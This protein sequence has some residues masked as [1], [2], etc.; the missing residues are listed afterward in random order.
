MMHQIRKMVGLILAISR[1]HVK[2]DILNKAFTLGKVNIPR[3][4]GLGLML[5]FVHYDRYNN[6][7][8]SDGVHDKLLWEEEKEKVD[9]FA[10]KYIFPTIIDTEINEKA[11]LTWLETKLSKHTFDG[12]QEEDANEEE[13]EDEGEEPSANECKEEGG[14]RAE[15]ADTDSDLKRQSSAQ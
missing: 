8:G 7:Y 13:G 1:G 10:E 6:R 3:A 12:P 5:E 4:P 2:E 15:A 11:M 9:E 14:H